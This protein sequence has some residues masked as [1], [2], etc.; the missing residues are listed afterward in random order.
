[1]YLFLTDELY[2][3]GFFGNEKTIVGRAGLG[4]Y[5]NMCKPGITF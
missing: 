2:N 5:I 4:E 1:M 3:Q